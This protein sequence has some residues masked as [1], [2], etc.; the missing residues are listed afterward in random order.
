MIL[1]LEQTLPVAAQGRELHLRAVEVLEV[2]IGRE[3]AADVAE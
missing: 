3:L 1:R 2:E